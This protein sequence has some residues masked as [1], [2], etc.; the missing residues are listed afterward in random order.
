MSVIVK[1]VGWGACV[2]HHSKLGNA[3]LGG[4]ASRAHEPEATCPPPNLFVSSGFA[5]RTC[6]ISCLDLELIL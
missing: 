1:P 2:K 6:T 3:G 4:S 5:V